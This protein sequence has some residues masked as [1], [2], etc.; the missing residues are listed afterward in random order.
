MAKVFLKDDPSCLILGDNIY[1]G[2]DLT[3]IL[4]EADQDSE[5]A[6]IFTYQVKDPERFGILSIDKKGLPIKIQEK[7]K[8]PKSNLAITGLYFYPKNVSSIAKK[9]KPSTRGELEISDLNN[10]YLNKKLLRTKTLNRGFTW[11][12]TGTFDSLLEASNFI[13]LIQNRQN[14]IVACPEEI[15]FTNK[16]IKKTDL[17]KITKSMKNTYGDYLRELI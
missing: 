11:L 8:N 12:D 1:Y 4:K 13:S 3:K 10:D 5:N 7:P 17:L 9:L 16:W 2:N 15:A 14:T 6:T